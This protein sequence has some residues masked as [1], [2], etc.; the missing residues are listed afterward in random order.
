MGL[1]PLLQGSIPLPRGHTHTLLT[2]GQMGKL[3]S[4]NS[5][6]F[7][8][9]YRAIQGKV[10]FWACKKGCLISRPFNCEY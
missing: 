8:P 2:D 5:E 7:V 6:Q 3:E 1:T 10:G 4:L 9:L